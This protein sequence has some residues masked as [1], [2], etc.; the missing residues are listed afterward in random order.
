MLNI[1]NRKCN[2]CGST[3]GFNSIEE[4]LGNT[5]ESYGFPYKLKDFETLNYRQ[6]DC[7]ECGASD[8]DRLYKVFLDEHY[9]NSASKSIVDFAPAK[10][11]SKYL[12]G[13]F[14]HYRSADLF[15]DDVDDKVD[16]TDM[17]Q[18]KDG[19]FD[20]FVCSHIMEHVDD[21]A[22]LSELLRILK[23]GGMGILMTP[24]IKVEGA[25]DEDLGVKD[26]SERWRRF[27]QDDHV[28]LYTQNEF[29]DRI[30]R[31]GFTINKYTW[32]Q[33]GFFKLLSYGIDPKSV[34]YIV[35][36]NS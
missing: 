2:F 8:R 24:I 28:R 14:A 4:S 9:Q 22:A 12:S 15:M 6:Y 33:L 19:T 25:F 10:A 7:K 18:Y 3:R 21:A 20:F 26:V 23:P 31:A 11:L 34:L 13:E 16:I 27:A 1:F 5:L 30:K 29:T 17:K 32:R 36:K 35:E